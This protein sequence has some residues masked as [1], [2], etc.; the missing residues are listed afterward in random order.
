VSRS[1][2]LGLCLAIFVSACSNKSMH[3]T[4]RIG[5][6]DVMGHQCLYITTPQLKHFAI[7]T[8][9]SNLCAG[10][11]VEIDAVKSTRE[12]VCQVGIL[13]DVLSYQVIE[14]APPQIDLQN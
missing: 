8:E 2:A 11:D 3:L 13:L 4:G 1:A 12:T 7:Y 5:A 10:M 6:I 14:G 9:D